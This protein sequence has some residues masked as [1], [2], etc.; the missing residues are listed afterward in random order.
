MCAWYTQSAFMLK[1]NVYLTW[2]LFVQLWG[3]REVA[4]ALLFV[5]CFCLF[6]SGLVDYFVFFGDWD[7]FSRLE[8]HLI[9]TYFALYFSRILPFLFPCICCIF[10]PFFF[11]TFALP[12]LT[13]LVPNI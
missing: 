6:G 5:A 9:F 8:G 12:Y 4:L 11:P 10:C 2:L 3:V 7:I 13:L 1:K